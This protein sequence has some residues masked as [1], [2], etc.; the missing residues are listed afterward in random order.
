VEALRAALVDGTIDCVATDHAPHPPEL[1]DQEWEHAPCGMLG[2]ETAFALVNTHL[3][4]PGQLSPLEA[5]A[6][7]TSG[8]AGVRDVQ[9]HGGPIAA[10]HPANLTVLHPDQRW[11]V[12]AARLHSRARNSPYHGMELVG[13]PVH[14]LLR[15]TF[16]LRDGEVRRPDRESSR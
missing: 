16:T 7:F 5:V 11:T 4:R 10:G 15:G 2:L 1:K 3:V 14:T 6:R 13:R 8:P 12:D 9:G